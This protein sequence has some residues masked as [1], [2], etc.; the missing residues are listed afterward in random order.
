MIR[1]ILALSALALFP[2]RAGHSAQAQIS[3]GATEVRATGGLTKIFQDEPAHLTAGG[4]VRYYLTRRLSVQPGAFLAR[5][6]N[7]E[8][9]S[10]LA[11]LAF[12]FPASGGRVTPYVIGGVGLLRCHDKRIDYTS[13][14]LNAGGGFGAKV[15]LTP[16]LYVAPEVRLGTHAFPQATI[17]VGFLVS[18]R[19]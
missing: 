3:G 12:D 2:L 14:E 11:D 13:T 9:R 16:R 8:E 4:S 17:G 18:R 15:F 10:L 19:R 5:G 1:R 6:S 7:Y